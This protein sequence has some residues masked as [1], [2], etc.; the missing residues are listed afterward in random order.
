MWATEALKEDPNVRIVLVWFDT[1]VDVCKERVKARKNHPTLGPDMAD[2]VIDRFASGFKPPEDW[3]LRGP[4][5]ALMSHITPE[6]AKEEVDKL[7]EFL[8]Q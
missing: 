7:V 8:K 4:K 6:N 3:E 5:Y 2:E 1:P